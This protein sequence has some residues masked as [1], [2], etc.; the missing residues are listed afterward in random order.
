ME[1]KDWAAVVLGLFALGVSG[2]TFLRQ[3]SLQRDIEERQFAPLLVP[4]VEQEARGDNT[5]DVWVGFRHMR[6]RADALQ[7]QDKPLRMVMPVRNAGEGVAILL[8][9]RARPVKDCDD[10]RLKREAEDFPDDNVQRLHY[11]VVR[12]GESE[13]LFYNT[14]KRPKLAKLYRDAALNETTVN[15][16]I[17]YTD[18]LGKKLRW[19]C[20]IYTRG[21]TE[22]KLWSLSESVYGERRV[23]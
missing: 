21:T 11:Y 16:L 17:R 8:Q 14:R 7:L 9:Q 20:V 10:E 18:A 19:T 1:G 23:D 15:V 5:I 2:F 22:D 13:Q 6:K 3:D 4:G 12:P